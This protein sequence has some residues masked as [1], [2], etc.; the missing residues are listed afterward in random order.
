MFCPNFQNSEVALWEGCCL[1]P[2]VWYL[3]FLRSFS[4][5]L[6]FT[7]HAVS[8]H[9]DSREPAVKRFI[10]TFDSPDSRT[11]PLELIP[12]SFPLNTS[13]CQPTSPFFPALGF[14]DLSQ[15]L[16]SN[17]QRNKSSK[18]GLFSLEDFGIFSSTSHKGSA[19]FPLTT[20]NLFFLLY[21]QSLTLNRLLSSPVQ[22]QSP[23]ATCF[24]LTLV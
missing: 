22:P 14:S 4:Q 5:C 3:P 10:L 15:M 2:V 12:F 20:F 18:A 9:L 7:Q 13:P 8:F 6:L 21:F 23:P 11:L 16:P 19:N 24:C 17:L 1:L